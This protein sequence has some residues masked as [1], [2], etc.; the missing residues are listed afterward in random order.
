MATD[1]ILPALGMSQDS[2]KIVRWLKGEGEQVAQ[3]EPLVEIETDKATVE[4]EAPATGSLARI[5][6]AAGAEV[7]VGQV[8]ATILAQGEAATSVPQIAQ[9]DK[10][11]LAVEESAQSGGEAAFAQALSSLDGRSPQAVSPRPTV[12]PA[13]LLASR[14]AADRGIDLSQ[15][16][17]SGQRVQKADVLAYLQ[18]AAQEKGLR[19]QRPQGN[20]GNHQV[21]RKPHGEVVKNTNMGARFRRDTLNTVSLQALF[22]GDGNC[23]GSHMCLLCNCKERLYVPKFL[24]HLARPSGRTPSPQRCQQLRSFPRP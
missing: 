11:R 4:I 23:I 1:V 16:K 24:G 15:V 6:A 9:A 7:P 18:N 8:I 13:S 3:G 21:G 2:G 22:F 20:G 17:A 10:G 19:G 12:V 5:A 14:I